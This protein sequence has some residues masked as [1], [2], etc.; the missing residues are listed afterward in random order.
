[1][2]SGEAS[3]DPYAD[4]PDASA[5]H[6]GAPADSREPFQPYAQNLYDS[7]GD[8][9]SLCSGFVLGARP[10]TPE[11]SWRSVQLNEIYR[12]LF[13]VASDNFADMDVIVMLTVVG[14]L[15]LCIQV[16]LAVVLGNRAKKFADSQTADP[17]AE[18]S[19]AA[20]CRD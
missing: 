16:P 8:R 19:P 1:M 4:A 6:Q 13:Q 2:A 3:G 17:A 20:P 14:F 5:V 11:A 18:W 7:L 10:Q 15:G 12:R 9:D